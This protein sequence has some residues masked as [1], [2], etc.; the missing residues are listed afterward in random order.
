MAAGAHLPVVAAYMGCRMV[1]MRLLAVAPMV[2]V[3]FVALVMRSAVAVVGAFVNPAVEQI[4][5]QIPDQQPAEYGEDRTAVHG[6]GYQIKTHH[7]EH[8]AGGKA[9]QQA[10][11]PL[12][13][14]VD[15]RRQCAAQRQSA[16]AGQCGDSQYHCVHIHR[17]A[18]CYKFQLFSIDY[19]GWKSQVPEGQNSRYT[20]HIPGGKPPAF[21]S[22]DGAVFICKRYGRVH[23]AALHTSQT[24]L[25]LAQSR[26]RPT[27]RRH[28]ASSRSRPSASSAGWKDASHS[29]SCRSSSGL[30]HIPTAS[31]AR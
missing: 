18:P 2:F 6:V 4:G 26:L 24:Q 11:R 29:H 22:A 20:Q 28:S 10:D 5:T 13:R 16:Y 14:A 1:V 27:A 9:Q 7:A 23:F 21:P 30:R 31:P 3:V 15:R 25:P 19:G 12:R 8:N 17:S